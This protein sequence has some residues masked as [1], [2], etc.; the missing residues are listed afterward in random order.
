MHWSDFFQLEIKAYLVRL[1]F[2][3]PKAQNRLFHT[4]MN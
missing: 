3:S 1:L 2:T 4:L